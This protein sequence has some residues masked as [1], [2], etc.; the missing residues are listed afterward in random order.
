MLTREDY[1]VTPSTN[2]EILRELNSAQ[3]LLDRTGFRLFCKGFP[4]RRFYESCALNLF[5]TTSVKPYD[6]IVLPNQKYLMNFNKYTSPELKRQAE[7]S[8]KCS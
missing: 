5:S 6:L 4:S 3:E 1:Y 2:F 8:E 7:F